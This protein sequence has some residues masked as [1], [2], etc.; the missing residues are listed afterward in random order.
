MEKKYIKYIQADFKQLTN[1][2]SMPEQQNQPVETGKQAPDEL[3]NSP[4]A[5]GLSALDGTDAQSD[6]G[7][8]APQSTF[9]KLLAAVS[10]FLESLDEGAGPE[11]PEPPEKPLKESIRGFVGRCRDRSDR[12][13][14]LKE[15]G[16]WCWRMFF[17]C[18]V[19]FLLF[20][21]TVWSTVLALDFSENHRVK[22]FPPADVANYLS[23]EHE[24]LEAAVRGMMPSVGKNDDIPFERFDAKL[25]ETVRPIRIY[26]DEYGIYFMT[27]KGWYNGEHGIFIA[28]DEGNMPPDLNWGLIRGRIFTYAIYD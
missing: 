22:F 1:G 4:S 3:R 17:R 21:L 8:A 14:M 13:A 5:A 10:S 20:V 18:T 19:V 7:S 28:K 23:A 15:T 12:A 11:P 9:R 6:P 25:I 16:E 27:S 24:S 2:L 26:S